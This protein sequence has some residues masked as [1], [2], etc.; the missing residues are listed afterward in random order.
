M[1]GHKL[2]HFRTE[3]ALREMRD[4]ELKKHEAQLM[5]VKEEESEHLTRG[6]FHQSHNYWVVLWCPMSNA[7]GLPFCI[8]GM[9]RMF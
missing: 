8:V 4:E 6:N 2:T 1:R 5:R 7:F 3:R 9:K